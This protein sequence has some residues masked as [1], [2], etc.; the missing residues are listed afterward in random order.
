MS[1][2]E[3]STTTK[4]NHNK[5]RRDKPW[6]SEDIDHWK[7]EEWKPEYMSKPMLEES[8]FATL[9]PAYR[10]KYLREV[11]P[12]VTRVLKKEGIACELNLIEGSM[13]V[14]TT[15]KTSDPY[16]IMKAR[17]LIKLLARSIPMEQA[18]KILEDGMQCDVIK[19]GG[20]VRN[21]EKFAKRRQRLLGPN[22]HTL[23]AIELLTGCYVMVQ[24]NTVS[25]M[26]SFKGLK[27][28]RNI[29]VDCMNNVHPIYNVKSLMIKREL[30]K[31]PELANED[32]TRFLPHFKNRNTAKKK[33]ATKK[34]KKV[35]TPFPPSQQP[36]KVD[37]QLESGE[38]FL[39]EAQRKQNREEEK[40]QKSRERLGERQRIR[41]KAFEAPEEVEKVNRKRKSTETSSANADDELERL[42]SSVVS[43]SKGSERKKKRKSIV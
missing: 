27:Q 35:Y 17:D 43:K 5:Y 36:S 23:K 26:G 37:M 30:E 11:W 39:S 8:S 25:A 18:V 7:L 31:D 28:V 4:K 15:R 6:D 32:W 3:A 33:K 40:K 34:E 14:R 2:Q 1:G 38:Y 22:G 12:S 21:K 10:E 19:I 29:V 13:T 9:F 24:G 20:I 42:K 41:E 16:I